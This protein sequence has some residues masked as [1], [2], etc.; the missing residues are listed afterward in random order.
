[1]GK[2]KLLSL[3]TGIGAYEKALKNLNIDYELVNYCEWDKYASKAYSLIFDEPEEKNLGDIQK[4]DSKKLPDF[5]I[6]TYSFPC[7]SFSLQGKKLGFDDPNS[8]NMFFESA[9]II[10]E[11]KPK[12]AIFENVKNLL[13]HDKGNTMSTILETLNDLGYNTY[14]K[15]LRSTFFGVPQIR[16]R[17]Y[18]VSIR[19]D[20]DNGEFEFPVGQETSLT[21]RDIID[22][23]DKAIDKGRMKESLK[24]Y[25]D[26][27]YHYK[28][29][30][31]TSYNI[32]V[33][34]DGV[35]MGY[36]K[37]SW[38]QNKILSIDGYCPTLVCGLDHTNCYEIERHLNNLERFRLQGFD[39]EDYFKIADKMSKTQ[40][41]KQT[42]NSM[43]V[44][45]IQ[46]IFQN[47]FKEEKYDG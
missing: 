35:K 25:L 33:L 29:K 34:F 8:G 7:T 39:D 46:A 12:Y 47:L 32:H 20:I 5:D 40:M 19:K 23:E 24:K 37:S 42:G 26:P 17:V 43:S 41:G 45:V 4:I 10:K 13:S 2:L 9:K 28:P 6:M 1:M 14:Y 22:W 27:K 18:A 31:I 36:Y 3:F 15:V 16:E 11:K 21:I 38:M 30:K 44:P